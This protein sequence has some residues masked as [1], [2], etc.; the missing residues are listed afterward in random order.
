M[1]DLEMLDVEN[2]E[3]HQTSTL[4]HVQPTSE[5]AARSAAEV[6]NILEKWKAV[7]NDGPTTAD[8]WWVYELMK[9]VRQDPDAKYMIFDAALLKRSIYATLHVHTRLPIP[10]DFAPDVWNLVSMLPIK[11]REQIERRLLVDLMMEAAR[12]LGRRWYMEK[13]ARPAI[14]AAIL[15]TCMIQRYSSSEQTNNELGELMA[16][17][18]LEDMMDTL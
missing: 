11:Q 3:E 9:F 18:A 13:M 12:E 5:R 16:K 15:H 4:C 10:A 7:L 2:V 17:A 14:G 8:D 1:E 6:S